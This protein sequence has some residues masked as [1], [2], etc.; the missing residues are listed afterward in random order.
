MGHKKG[1]VHMKESG[2]RSILLSQGCVAVFALLL[3]GLDLGGYWLIRWYVGL[4]GMHGQTG[5]GILIVFYVC[6]VFAWLCLLRLWRLLGNLKQGRVFVEDNV[7][8]LSAVSR[9]CA[10]V[11]LACL[12]GGAV[13]APILVISLAAGFMGLIVHIVKNVFQQAIA[14]KSELDLT[15]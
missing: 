9:C 1:A 7:G 12:I 8:H 4:R 14:M 5:L 6:S 13:Y 3:L 11:C 15:I 2:D 10:G